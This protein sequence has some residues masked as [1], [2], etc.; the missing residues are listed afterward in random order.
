MSSVE[1]T[2]QEERELTPLQ[3]FLTK[4]LIVTAAAFGVLFFA[5]YLVE[6]FVDSRSEQIK[7]LQGGPAFWSEVERKL[8]SLA[9]EPDLPPEKKKKI[10]DALSRLST[11][12]RP[13]VDALTGAAV[14]H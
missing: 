11:K 6:S 1:S 10:V 13:Y 3:V 12:Y 5:S 14:P 8:Y 2:S 4:A 9:D 7:I